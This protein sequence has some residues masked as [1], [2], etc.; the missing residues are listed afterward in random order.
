VNLTQLFLILVKASFFSTG[1]SGNIGTL[2]QDLVGRGWATDREFAEGL[3]IGQISPGPTGLWVLSLGYLVAKWW[4][5]LFACVAI[6]FPPTLV[7]LVDR[8]LRRSYNHPAL[9]GFLEGLTAA[10]IGIMAT[11]LIGM[12]QTA[13]ISVR[14]IIIAVASLAAAATRR[15][16][17][18]VIIVIA[19]GVVIVRW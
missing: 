1:G 5:T 14:T 16:P 17:A 6:V 9:K 18:I 2:H 13:G 3:A 10:S 19:A 12:I 8:L 4:G 15:V 11:V 7:I